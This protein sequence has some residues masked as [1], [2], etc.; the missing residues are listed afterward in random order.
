MQ[1]CSCSQRPTFSSLFASEHEPSLTD[2]I[3]QPQQLPHSVQD[4]QFHSVR[5][6]MSKNN[7]ARPRTTKSIQNS[8]NNDGWHKCSGISLSAPAGHPPAQEQGGREIPFNEGHLR[9]H[10]G[11]SVPFV[12][13]S[14]PPVPTA[15]CLPPLSFRRATHLPTLL[16]S[17]APATS[18][19]SSGRTPGSQAHAPRWP[20][21]AVA[22]PAD[23]HTSGPGSAVGYDAGTAQTP[24]TL[25][26]LRR[27]GS[28]LG[29][30]P[31]H[32]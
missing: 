8:K 26:P 14:I 32:P 9:A 18:G 6:A 11:Q 12:R 5:P 19:P 15:F 7:H 23:W 25:A 22:T 29:S 17:A 31:A 2:H 1:R 4:D 13:A 30:T 24:H 20:D 16:C 21:E 28:L 10:L 3:T 27:S